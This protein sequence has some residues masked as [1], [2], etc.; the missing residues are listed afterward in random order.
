[1][2]VIGETAHIALNGVDH[3]RLH[4]LKTPKH[5]E[6]L[7]EIAPSTVAVVSH[8]LESLPKRE[9][10]SWLGLIKNTLS[11]HVI[12]ITHPELCQQQG[13]TFNDYLAMGFR[14]FAGSE[15]GLQLFTYAIENYQL[16]RD[17]LN[18]RFWA[19]PVLYDKYRW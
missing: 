11:P 4:Y 19:N 15:E 1:V 9:A 18:N 8:V 13:W 7:T 5:H 6:Q 3:T 10:E 12:L 14:H 2:L 17:W 16:K